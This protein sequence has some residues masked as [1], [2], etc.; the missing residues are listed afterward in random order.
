M[1]SQSPDE[2]WPGAVCCSRTKRAV[3]DFVPDDNVQATGDREDERRTWLPWVALA[4]VVALVIW[5]LLTYGDW[6][7]APTRRDAVRGTAT[8]VTVPDVTGKEEAEA[9]RLLAKAG[10]VAESVA[11]Y[12]II[13]PPGTVSAQNPA[14]SSRVPRGSVVTIEVVAEQVGE[15]TG[16]D[17]SEPDYQG[18]AKGMTSRPPKVIVR[19]EVPNLVGLDADAASKQLEAMGLAPRTMYQ[20]QPS[21]V[22][23]VYQQD[24]PPGER[25]PVGEQVH[26]LVGLR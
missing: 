18:E 12:D 15:E 13:S 11:S 20:P 6:T 14:G 2:V 17:T 19:R 16:A 24:P 25:I 8:L 23:R 1:E 9:Q 3:G 22:G 10:L 5:L 21:S 26:M 7:V 4:A